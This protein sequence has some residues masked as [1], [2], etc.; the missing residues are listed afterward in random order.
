MPYGDFT[1]LCAVLPEERGGVHAVGNSAADEGEEV[2][3]HRRLIRVLEEQLA[4]D[5]EDNRQNNKAHEKN[6]A[7]RR[8]A[9]RLELSSERVARHFLKNTHFL[10]Y[11]ELTAKGQLC[12][13]KKILGECKMK[14]RVAREGE[15]AVDVVV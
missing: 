15:K 2:E 1:D 12:R 5:I 14:E 9:Q 7:L 6:G 4:Q 3:D 11:D 8:P 10:R 13:I